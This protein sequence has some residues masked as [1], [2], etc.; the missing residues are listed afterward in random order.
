MSLSS[1]SGQMLIFGGITF[2]LTYLCSKPLGHGMD[3]YDYVFIGSVMIVVFYHR[4]RREAILKQDTGNPCNVGP[5]PPL[6]GVVALKTNETMEFTKDTIHVLIF[7]ATYCSSSRSAVRLLAK[8]LQK[9]EKVRIILLTQE[10]DTELS[11]V[12]WLKDIPF[13]VAIEDGKM[14]KAYQLA[15]SN[16]RLPHCYIIDRIGELVWQGH[17]LGN[18]QDHINK[19]YLNKEEQ[20]DL[21]LKT[22]TVSSHKLKTD[23]EM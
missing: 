10:K 13:E 12:L 2:L 14:F 3:Q 16:T 19:A 17:P 18:V 4:M 11:S 22:T 15:H 1:P 7:F 5:A 6:Q 9:H 23:K 20:G 8:Q 21:P